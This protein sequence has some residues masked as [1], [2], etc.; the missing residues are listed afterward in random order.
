MP[1]SPTPCR[2]QPSPSISIG[3][4]GSPVPSVT[5]RRTYGWR[6][7][8]RVREPS[9]SDA[10]VG[11]CSECVCKSSRKEEP[12]LSRSLGRKSARYPRLPLPAH[13]PGQRP[14]CRPRSPWNSRCH[15]ERPGG[16]P[17]RHAAEALSSCPTRA[18]LAAPPGPMPHWSCCRQ[19]GRLR[20]SYGHPATFSRN[21]SD[22]NGPST[23]CVSL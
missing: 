8:T 16:N 2:D 12:R 11:R 1:I 17:A 14:L 7:C 21:P 20:Q 4:R 22:T 9:R 23:L 18:D 3:Q 15:H 5:P 19:A 13:P 10:H 6:R